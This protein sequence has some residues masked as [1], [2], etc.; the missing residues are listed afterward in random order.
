MFALCFQGD[1][2]GPVVCK[3]QTG[4]YVVVGVSSFGDIPCTYAVN[5]KVS[6]Y[7]SW[8]TGITGEHKPSDIC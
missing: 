1:S 3:D 5:T 6:S 2:G 7:I 4:A 8:I